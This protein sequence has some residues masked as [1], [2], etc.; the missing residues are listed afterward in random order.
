VLDARI[1]PPDG[2]RF[3]DVLCIGIGGS[4]LGPQL[5]AQALG[6]DAGAPGLPL[7]FIDNTDPHGIDRVLRHLTPV[8]GTLLVLVTSKSGGTPETRNGMLETAEAF[9]RFGLPFASHAVAI[10]CEGSRL[11]TQAEREGWLRRFYMQDWVGGRTS[12]FSAVGLLPAALAGIDTAALLQGAAQMDEATR[13]DSP[14]GNPAARLALA[15]YEAGEQGQGRRD[16]VVLPYKDSLLLMSRYLQQLVMESL[17]KGQDLDGEPVAQGL[18]VYG[19]KGS[20]DQHAYV[21]QLREGLDNFFVTFIEV[22]QGR[23]PAQPEVFV[24]A[25]VTSADYLNGFLYGT[26]QALTENGRRSLTITVPTVDAR[27]IGALVALFERA[28]GLY[29]FL[30]NINAYHQPGVEAGKRAAGDRLALQRTLVEA[31]RSTSQEIA[32]DALARAAGTDDLE[33][34]Y[35][36]VRHLASNR[37]EITLLGDPRRPESVRVRYER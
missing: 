25:D 15:W 17:G 1:A 18:A 10:T 26:R 2:V 6:A 27:R 16:M 20:T 9:A 23:E 8:F 34:V 14:A 32:L 36:I 19:N 35:Q 11:D 31:L 13:E 37:A 30:V 4:A 24:E 29:A 7:H 22:L 33:S 3:T 21:Q 12:L 28:V 5:L